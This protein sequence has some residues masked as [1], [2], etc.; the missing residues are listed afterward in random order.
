MR[1]ITAL[2][3]FLAVT[4]PCSQ[5]FSYDGQQ[6]GTIV[7]IEGTASR[8][9]SGNATSESLNIDAP[10]YAHDTITTGKDSRALIQFEDDTE[11]TMGEDTNLTIDDYIFSPDASSTTG[12]FSVLKGAFLFVSGLISKNPEHDVSIETSY[13]TIG[14]RGTTV[15]GGELD[16]EYGVLVQKGSVEV[17]NNGGTQVIDQGFGTFMKSKLDKPRPAALWATEKTQKAVGKIA[18]QRSDLVQK[19]LAENKIRNEALR[20]T[21][22]NIIEDK[23]DDRMHNQIKKQG[24]RLNDNLT[25]DQRKQR[26]EHLMKS[27]NK[28]GSEPG[29]YNK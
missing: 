14:L 27:K 29:I 18:L 23:I 11:I 17:K 5:A 24:Q 26:F 25:P 16:G 22:K 15:W 21:R 10:V 28:D 9:T 19:K 3:L 8:A 4:W 13:G 7:E 2:F 6:I 12:K 1:M 20:Q